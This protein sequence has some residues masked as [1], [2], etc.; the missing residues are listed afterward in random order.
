MIIYGDL[1]SGNCL[2]AKYL[3]D[4]LGLSYDWQH[5][6]IWNGGAKTDEFLALNPQGQVPVVDLGN[7]QILAQSNAILRYLAHS[8]AVLPT[9][10]FAAAKVDEWLFWEQ[11]SHEPYVA[12]CRAQMVYQ[13]KGKD[14]REPWRVERGEQ[15]LDYLDRM[16]ASN[17]F[18]ANN[19]FSIA[20]IA[21]LAYSRLAEQGGFDLQPRP[22][23]KAW[24][25]RCE[26]LLG[27]APV[28][29]S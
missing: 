14:E 27:L 18:L 20:D 24:I 21:L 16:L 22:A 3:A 9:D 1:T 25:G 2:K 8:A 17:D 7:G 5:V 19:T 15:A 12:V 28:P 4:H 29:A 11:Y 26:G 6:D 23:L 13:G 10:P